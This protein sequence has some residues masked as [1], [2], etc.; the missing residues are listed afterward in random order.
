[1]KYNDE[2][3]KHNAWRFVIRRFARVYIH[4]EGFFYS[5]VERENGAIILLEANYVT[6]L[7]KNGK[8]NLKYGL[9]RP[10]PAG[11]TYDGGHEIIHN[12]YCDSLF[13]CPDC[14]R[15]YFPDKDQFAFSKYFGKP[16][17]FGTFRKQDI[18]S[19]YEE[20][21]NS[22][23]FELSECKTKICLSEKDK[24]LGLKLSS[25]DKDTRLDALTNAMESYYTNEISNISDDSYI[26]R[27]GFIYLIKA[28]EYVKI[29]IADDIKI[30]LKQ[31]QGTC[32]L[33]LEIIN[34]WKIS[35]PSYYENLLH[36]QYKQYRVH[37]EWFKLPEEEVNLLLKSCSFEEAVKNKANKF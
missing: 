2:Y 27:E 35:N 5:G 3:F 28:D 33:R 7:I 10:K 14:G 13:L 12:I 4:E 8:E 11:Y 23:E 21:M 9:P 1:M 34:F 6:D 30:R 32:P 20:K 17:G 36:K 22:K 16:F 18:T 29:G 37:G 19:L 31:I 24:N 25:E 26:N 15:F